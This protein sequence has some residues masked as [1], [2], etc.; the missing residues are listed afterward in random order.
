MGNIITIANTLRQHYR[1]PV[2][3]ETDP[4]LLAWMNR[5]RCIVA[6]LVDA[7]GAELIQKYMNPEAFIHKNMIASVDT[8]YPPTTT[9]ATTGFLT[10]KYPCET[11]W[12]SWHQYFRE[13]DDEMILFLGK[14][15]YSRREYGKYAWE[16]LP[17][18][19]LD[20]ELQEH[21]IRADSIW[22]SFG[23]NGCKTFEKQCAKTLELVKDPQ[24]QFLYVYW[25]ELDAC[26][27]THGPSSAKAQ[28]M[29]AVISMALEGLSHQLP[30]DVGLMVVADHG[31]VDIHCTL[32]GNDQELMDMLVRK[33]S[34]EARVIS[35]YV[36]Q[37]QK[38]QFRDLFTQKY[39]QYYHLYTHEEVLKNHLFGEGSEAARF[40]EFIGDYVACAYTEET[41]VYSEKQILKGHHAGMMSAEMKIP[42]IL[43]PTL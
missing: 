25:D 35:F 20:E 38:E 11:G 10:G 34:F 39:G 37:E 21:G 22:P 26:M 30:E 32:I 23:H 28:K 8:V 9:A 2:Y 31:Q 15:E 43:Y 4:D 19:S 18:K 14:G 5:Y 41:L 1:L 7:M 27:H 16:A 3:H 17:V 12:I 42:L 6:V 33:P 36:R 29:M 13:L 24:L 40:E